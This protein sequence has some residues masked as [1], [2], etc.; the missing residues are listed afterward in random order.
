MVKICFFLLTLFE[1]SFSTDRKLI[2]IN[3][4]NPEVVTYQA[5]II[6]QGVRLTETDAGIF[7]S[8]VEAISE[9]ESLP[10][11]LCD[12]F[13]FPLLQDCLGSSDQVCVADF[14]FINSSLGTVDELKEGAY[15]GY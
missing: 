1:I 13:S 3:N 7:A 6:T 9:K 5:W 14:K 10:H 2:S 4:P 15:E 12:I 11:D 8:G